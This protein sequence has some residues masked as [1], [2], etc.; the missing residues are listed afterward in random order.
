[1]SFSSQIPLRIL[2]GVTT[3]GR[4]GLNEHSPFVKTIRRPELIRIHLVL[5]IYSCQTGFTVLLLLIEIF[6]SG[7]D[8]AQIVLERRRPLLYLEKGACPIV[9]EK[10]ILL[11]L[12]DVGPSVLK[13]IRLWF[14]FGL[15]LV[16]INF[17][18]FG[19][20][21]RYLFRERSQFPIYRHTAHTESL[22][23]SIKVTLVVIDHFNVRH[24]QS[25][26]VRNILW[27]QSK[28]GSW[29]EEINQWLSIVVDPL[30][31]RGDVQYFFPVRV[32]HNFKFVVLDVR[33]HINFLILNFDYLLLSH[34]E[35]RNIL[36]LGRTVT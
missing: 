9:R 29:T 15:S 23:R 4:V 28:V 14:G 13:D 20:H 35:W 6:Q 27:G 21:L 10:Q 31:V 36:F 26:F 18:G 33:L 24:M 19:A 5:L 2:D 1:M 17:R 8:F 3:I 7:L 22:P 16:E 30:S 11:R 12:W 25:L 32:V 34:I